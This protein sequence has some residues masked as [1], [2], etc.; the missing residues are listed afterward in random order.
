M[1]NEPVEISRRGYSK[2]GTAYEKAQ[3]SELSRHLQGTVNKY[4]LA[5]KRDAKMSRTRPPATSWVTGGFVS[6]AKKFDFFYPEENRESLKS[7]NCGMNIL[8]TVWEG[9]GS[10][11]G[12]AHW[13]RVSLCGQ[14]NP[15]EAMITSEA[16]SEKECTLLLALSWI[17]HSGGCGST[18]MGRSR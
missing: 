4:I 10:G 18:A 6:C 1:E 13:V 15:A 16:R 7:F 8:G 9:I 11:N 3:R 5:R 14:Q 12:S 2:K 17:T